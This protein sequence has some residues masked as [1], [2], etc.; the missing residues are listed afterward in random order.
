M[1][2][3]LF[4]SGWATTSSVWDTTLSHL[5]YPLVYHLPWQ[6]FLKEKPAFLPRPPICIGWSL[7][8]MLALQL[9]VSIPLSG[10]VLVSST[11]RIT[12][13]R[14]Y[15]GANP[16]VLEAMEQGLLQNKKKSL[17]AF[18]NGSLFSIVNN[19]L[20]E[21]LLDTAMTLPTEDLIAGLRYL[22]STDLRPLLSS[23]TTPC[24]IIHSRQDSII[25]YESSSYLADHIH[26]S[27]LRTLD[28]HGHA[29]PV[30]Q[31]PVIASEIQALLGG[32]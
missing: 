7:G 9:A 17:Q 20:C 4:I 26:E 18:F 19:Q 10:L 25:S 6:S 28:G 31:G 2:P 29:L 30:T 12:E 8:G 13:D 22:A 15:K 3:L 11:A 1:T 21:R 5:N 16:A 24:R 23:I 14:D 27:S 32:S